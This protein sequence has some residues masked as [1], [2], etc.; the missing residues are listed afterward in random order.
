MGDNLNSPTSKRAPKK[1]TQIRVKLHVWNEG[2]I[3]FKRMISNILKRLE[4]QSGTFFRN[5]MHICA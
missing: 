5:K 1:S 4:I 3:I 2:K